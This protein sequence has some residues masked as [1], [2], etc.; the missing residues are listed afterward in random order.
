M[1]FYDSANGKG[2]GG[3]KLAP[4]FIFTADFKQNYQ[5]ISKLICLRLCLLLL[6]DSS[7]NW[8][9]SM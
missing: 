9:S 3:E 4:L 7:G 5:L 2:G 8:L 6:V 1:F